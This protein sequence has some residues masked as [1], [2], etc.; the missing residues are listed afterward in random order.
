[1]KKKIWLLLLTLGLDLTG[2]VTD[3]RADKVSDGVWKNLAHIALKSQKV[4]DTEYQIVALGAGA[5]QEQDIEAAWNDFAAK[6]ADGRPFT[7]Q[8]K[9]E[10]YVYVES[11]MRHDAKRLVGTIT[12]TGPEKMK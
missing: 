5:S 10:D 2:C 7:K 6:I 11:Y 1:M 12:I 4:S 9:M 3:Y 8:A